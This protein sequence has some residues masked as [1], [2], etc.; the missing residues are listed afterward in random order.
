VSPLP[1]APPAPAAPPLLERLCRATNRQAR[2]LFRL[3]N[4]CVVSTAALIDVLGQLGVPARPLRVEAHLHNLR[5]RSVAGAAL[6][7]DG[8]G[9]RRPAAPAGHWRGHLAAVA[10]VDGQAWL[11]DPT[12]DQA[13]YGAVP[14]VVP[15]D[16]AFLRGGR[17]VNHQTGPAGAEVHYH[18]YRRQVGWAHTPAWRPRAR[19]ELVARVLEDPGED[20]GR[21]RARATSWRLR[22]DD[23]GTRARR[24][25]G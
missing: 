7:W 20:V 2:A 19:R 4:T 11:L 9:T 14:M 23:R 8:D 15:I 3:R 22:D 25:T 5:D 18:T 6:G 10:E 1:L 16:E 17:W 24:V 21:G 13:G 12:L